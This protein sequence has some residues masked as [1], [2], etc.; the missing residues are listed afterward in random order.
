MRHHFTCLLLFTLFW[1]MA[2]GAVSAAGI[3]NYPKLNTPEFW[4]RLTPGGEK[5]I[6]DR[7]GIDAFNQKITEKSASVYR[8]KN[9]PATISSGQLQA[10]LTM[11]N[12]LNE[13]LYANGRLI[14]WQ[15]KQSLLAECNLDNIDAE[16][17]VSHG[18][19]LRRT[20]LRTLPSSVGL[21]STGADTNFDMLQETAIDPAEPILILHTSKSGAFYYIQMRNYRGWAAAKDIAALPYHDWLN[22]AEPDNFLIVTDNRFSL[23]VNDEDLIYQMGAKLPLLNGSNE[24]YTVRIPAKSPAG[25]FTEQTAA[26]NANAPVHLGYLPY[27][28]N[29][30]ISQSFK[31]LHDPYGW[32]GLK[33]SVDCSSFIADIYRSFG[34]EL[35]RNADEQEMSAGISY[36]M[37]NLTNAEKKQALRQLKAGDALFFDGHTML[38]L[39]MTNDTPFIIHSLGSHTKHYPGGAR[40]K[41]RTMQVVVS[42]LSLQRY[43]GETFLDALT[44]AVSYHD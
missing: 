26:I 27:T 31:F 15:Y 24:T 19:T 43:S 34:I 3:T 36:P 7:V 2:P 44:S 25:L 14:D 9:Y 29:Q 6:I 35:P 8:L 18:V 1:Q 11:P 40:E 5:S 38:Y 12:L 30:I 37:Q 13:S 17:A 20:N 28:R 16:I 33:N 23:R 39:G 41:I 10:W 42:D 21:F 32:G 4:H 22:Y